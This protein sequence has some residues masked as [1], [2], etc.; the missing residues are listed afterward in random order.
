[1]ESVKALGSCVEDRAPLLEDSY[2][3]APAIR[4]RATPRSM[5]RGLDFEP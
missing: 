3:L 2:E 5:V 1:M 4:V